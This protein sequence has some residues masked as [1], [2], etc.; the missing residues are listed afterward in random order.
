M[1]Q[2]WKPTQREDG[3]QVLGGIHFYH[4][5]ASWS[6]HQSISIHIQAIR[7]ERH[8]PEG[9][10]VLG[11]G[12][13]QTVLTPVTGVSLLPGALVGLVILIHSEATG[14]WLA[15]DAS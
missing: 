10:E 2:G 15:T 4:L 6:R 8:L 13:R 5:E 11:Q 9:L 3:K 12:V 1:E 14:A 7:I